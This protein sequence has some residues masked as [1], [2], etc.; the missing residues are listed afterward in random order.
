[1]RG[2][3]VRACRALDRRVN[4]SLTSAKWLPLCRPG[5]QESTRGALARVNGVVFK[6]ILVDQ[7]GPVHGPPEGVQLHR[8][9]PPDRPYRAHHLLRPVQR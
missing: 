8:A 5:L 7:P 6:G 9:R 3:I 2:A 1:M 4:P